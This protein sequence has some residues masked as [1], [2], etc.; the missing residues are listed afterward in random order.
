MN[1]LERALVG[2]G[3]E[4]AVP[5]APDL[6]PAVLAGLERRGPARRT[7]PRRRWAIAIA[8]FVLAVLAATLAIPDARSAFF[9]VFSIGASASS[10]STSFPRSSSSTTSS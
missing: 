3:Q 5:E 9:R 1:E 7:S 6:V 8:V 10:S 2:L 4:L